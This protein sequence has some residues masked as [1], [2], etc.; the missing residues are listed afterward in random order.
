M[1]VIE[2]FKFS[3]NGVDFSVDVVC[4]NEF[5]SFDDEWKMTDDHQGGVTVK[6][7]EH[8]R[9]S[10]KYAIPLQYTLAERIQQLIR[11]GD[12]NPSATA[13]RNAQAALKRD[14]N[15]S[16]YSFMISAEIDGAE[17]FNDQRA[18]LGFDYSYQDEGSL[19]ETA[20]EIFK[21]NGMEDEAVTMATGAAREIIAKMESFKKIA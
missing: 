8:D 6:N 4:H 12:D 10:Y 20:Q 9:G 17:L 19:L 15:A 18:D 11:N 21:E 13:Y 16:D 2:T 1:D 3:K 7:P 5:L 14:I